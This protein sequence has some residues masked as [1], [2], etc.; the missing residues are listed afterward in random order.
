MVVSDLNEVI[1]QL[2]REV[3][4]PIELKNSDGTTTKLQIVIISVCA[5]NLGICFLLTMG[6]E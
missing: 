1:L 4:N 5:D 6:F 2:A 3:A